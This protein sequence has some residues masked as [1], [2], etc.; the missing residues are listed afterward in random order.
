MVAPVTVIASARIVSTVVVSL[1]A[2]TAV[3]TRGSGGG[4]NTSYNHDSEIVEFL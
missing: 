2:R 4:A 1:P 3:F